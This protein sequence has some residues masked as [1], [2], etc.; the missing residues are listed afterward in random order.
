M[1]LREQP[2]QHPAALAVTDRM[3]SVWAALR[4][5]VLLNMLAVNLYRRDEVVHTGWWA[6]ILV[7]LIGWSIFTLWAYRA[8]RRG[9]GGLLVI[10]LTLATA[11]LLSSAWVK[12]DPDT[13]TVP[14]FWVMSVVLAWA[15]HWRWRG[16]LLAAAVIS[17]TD[18]VIRTEFT[19][20]NYGYTFLLMIGGPLV[21]LMCQSLQ[22]MAVQR[23]AAER[24]AAAAQERQRLARTVHDGVLQVLALV[25]RRGAEFAEQL[26]QTSGAQAQEL[27]RLAGE[28]EQAL[29]SLVHQWAAPPADPAYTHV[30]DLAAAVTGLAR[31]HPG[32][33]VE[34]ATPG[35][36]VE[37]P[38]GLVDELVAAAGECLANISRHVGPDARAWVLLED[39]GDQVVV[40]VRD[41]GPG[42]P[43]GRLA[44]AE[45]SG[46]LGVSQSIRA[47]LDDLGGHALMHT[48][49]E[50][51]EW[52]LTAP[53]E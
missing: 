28:Q 44:A 16:G 11:A 52:E 15:I 7:V 38:S 23:D 20:T 48:G 21:G 24:A 49:P 3:F 6:S 1:T 32:L 10:D 43:E 34:V 46:R 35:V 50:G 42:I 27:A 19:A 25:Q 12:A 41:E 18:F 37:L 2:W 33:Q 5:L 13:A 22:Q 14:G 47:R 17:A 31:R 39:L 45:A 53:R 51:T 40:S 30:S 29:R 9:L 4:V 8:R 26:P 36:A